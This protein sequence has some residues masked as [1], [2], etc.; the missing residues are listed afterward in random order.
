MIEEKSI[1]EGCMNQNRLAQ[2]KLYEFFVR[3][4]L[5]VCQRYTHDKD[6]AEDVLQD[7]FVKVFQQIH[8]FRFDCPLEQ[9]IKRV[10]INTAIS[11][12]RKEKTWHE[13]REEITPWSEAIA[14]TETT[15]SSIQYEQLLALIRSLPAGC[16]AVFN[17]YA[18]EGFEHKEIAE[19][20][21]IS[22]G[23]SKS[24]YHRAK[25]LLQQKL[26]AVEAK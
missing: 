26:L 6:D 18:I 4:M 17:L 11:F 15:I 12:L 2:K 14:D 5:V 1:V 19:L 13:G 9:W 24:Q 22:E 21:K 8:T 10:V 3:R 23:T 20:L 7:A 25:Q 16:Q